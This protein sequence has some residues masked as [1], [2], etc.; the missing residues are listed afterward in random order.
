MKPTSP[1]RNAALL[2]RDECHALRGLAIIGIFLHN[3]C[4]WL[5]PIVKE[6]EY[7]F[8]RKNTEWLLQVLHAPDQLLPI[9]LLSFFGHYGVPVFLFLSAY[10]LTMKYERKPIAAT[11]PA[12]ADPSIWA[13]V[14]F[15]FLKLFR[16]MI[17]GFVAFTML[18]AITPGRHHYHLL[19]IVAQMGMF[20]N[21]LP[22]PDRI[23]WPGPYWFFGLMLQLYVVYR[24]LLFRKSTATTITLMIVCLAIQLLCAPESEAL[25]RWRYNF[26]G[27]MLPFG[28]GII[29]ARHGQWLASWRDRAGHACFDALN[30]LL[31]AALV[32]ALS[33]HYVTWYFVPLFVCSASIALARIAGGT[34][35]LSF[36][37]RFLVWTGTLSAALFVSHPITRKI[38]IPLSRGNDVYAGLLLYIIA[39]LCVAWLFAT[40]MR[41]IPNPTLSQPKD[42][43]NQ[44]H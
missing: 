43:E 39:S 35:W 14:R 11:P 44:G 6:N 27:G 10:G 37:S 41:K 12:L 13:F 7:Q 1:H 42:H 15:H 31:S 16:M 36:A 33:L 2:S 3:Y 32:F 26:V 18:D 30:L 22:T 25:N 29:Y 34:P 4:H 19:D 38:F 20:N 17:V 28:A 24:T 5:G 9:H 8:F 23:I 21:L 40:L